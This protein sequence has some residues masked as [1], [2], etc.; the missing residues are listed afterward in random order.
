MYFK[1]ISADLDQLASSTDLDLY[2]LHKQ[3]IFGF[4]RTRVNIPLDKAHFSNYLYFSTKT[5]LWVLYQGTLCL[6]LH[7]NV[8]A[9]GTQWDH[10]SEGIQMSTHNIYFHGKI[11]LFLWKSLFLV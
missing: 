6:F 10:L 4:S 5:Y 11:K 1:T 2:C 9:V 7:K 3:G 8:Y